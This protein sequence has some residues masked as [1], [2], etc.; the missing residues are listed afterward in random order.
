[1][2]E[3]SGSPAVAGP[4]NELEIAALLAA[5]GPQR[6]AYFLRRACASGKVWGLHSDG[7]AILGEGN[8]RLLPLWPDEA[9]A[10]HFRQAD[11]AAYAPRSIELSGFLD[12]WLPGMKA[13]GME[14]AIFPVG[15]GDSV[16]VV[17]DELEANL[18]RGL[19]CC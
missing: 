10:E 8:R 2:P 18:R 6:Y 11:L 13:K 14:V 3:F 15:S 17:L 4:P 1:M 7:W 9:F 12:Q 19:G 16:F 5:N